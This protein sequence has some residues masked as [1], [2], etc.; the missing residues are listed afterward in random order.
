MWKLVLAASAR[1]SRAAV[2]PALCVVAGALI[3][4]WSATS[5]VPLLVWG[6]PTALSPVWFAGLAMAALVIGPR[7]ERSFF[8]TAQRKPWLAPVTLGVWS[9][10]P[11]FAWIGTVLQGV[12]AQTP[13]LGRGLADV[14]ELAAPGVAQL[15]A[16][17]MTAGALL[18]A[19]REIVARGDA[20]SSWRNSALGCGLLAGWVGWTLAPV[21]GWGFWMPHVVCAMLLALAWRVRVSREVVMSPSVTFMGGRGAV[22]AVVG[23]M[24]LAVVLPAMWRQ[25]IQ[26]SAE[27]IHVVIG[28]MLGLV[29][30]WWCGRRRVAEPRNAAAAVVASLAVL[31]L[32]G[33]A[34]A[35]R[36][37]VSLWST[38]T[39][40]RTWRLMLVRG[41]MASVPMFA[42]AWPVSRLLG[43]MGEGWRPVAAVGM[44]CGLVAGSL[45]LPEVGVAALAAGGLAGLCATG[46]ALWVMPGGDERLPV[47]APSL[48]RSRVRFAV[49]GLAAGLALLAPWGVMRSYQPEYTARTLFSTSVFEAARNKVERRGLAMLDEGRCIARV[50]GTRSAITVWRHGGYQVQIRDNG[51]PVGSRSLDEQAYPQFSSEV[52]HAVLPLAIHER[53]EHVLIVGLGAGQSLESV[54]AAPVLSATCVEPKPEVLGA[55]RAAGRPLGNDDPLADERLKI[56]TMSA[57]RAW[58]T[59]SRFDAIL[60]QP[61]HPTMAAG[62]AWHTREFY[63]RA[64]SRLTT[65]GVFSQRLITVDLGPA[66]LRGLVATAQAEFREVMLV[67]GGPGEMVLLGTNSPAGLVRA[68]LVTRLQADHIRRRLSAAGLDWSVVLNHAAWSHSQ[69]TQ[70]TSD[71]RTSPCSVANPWLVFAIPEET[72]NWT[73]KLTALR[74]TLVGKAGRIADWIGD[75]A[76]APEIVRRLA[77]VKGQTDLMVKYGDEY[78]AYRQAV[79]EQ[80]THKPRSLLKDRSGKSGHLHDEDRRRMQ[81]FQA[82]ANAIKTRSLEDIERLEAFVRPYDPLLSFFVHAEAAEILSKVQPRQPE[83]ELRHRLHTIYYA[84]P[85]NR[86]VR[87]VVEAMRLVKDFPEAVPDAARRF[88]V[89]NALLQALAARWGA[90]GGVTPASTSQ[91]LGDIDSSLV[92]SEHLFA[93]QAESAVEAGWSAEDWRARHKVLD[94]YLVAPLEGYRQKLLPHH[95][96]KQLEYALRPGEVTAPAPS[97]SG[98]EFVPTVP[99]LPLAN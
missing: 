92:L 93:L 61:D 4:V 58:E 36:I 31:G 62:V 79:R 91:T 60:V 35:W 43:L 77:E 87:A 65:D 2:P 29:G 55:Y 16:I 70:F 76:D 6:G 95:H 32:W 38:A 81:Y 72:W 49:S 51:L 73:D 53:P 75:D 3:G 54:L 99:G 10:W 68:G 90:R 37:D 8:A 83:R 47:A 9:A 88:D 56:W 41:A 71:V 40:D 20:G 59:T 23:L 5:L 67:E 69:L 13:L 7:V 94:R 57:S 12:V 14:V 11:L 39:I 78:W 15:V 64:A 98:P 19:R 27:T 46:V 74:E 66:S 97:K 22:P 44:V 80:V 30:G 96:Q 48:L 34:I 21:T 42:L 24:L 50:D 33:W 52:L 89:R 1:L 45:L 84:P 82:L 18:A 85:R 26:L 28:G 86:S 17:L 63:R 25:T